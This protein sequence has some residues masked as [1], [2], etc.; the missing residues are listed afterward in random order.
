M[1]KQQKTN[2]Y[3]PQVELLSDGIPVYNGS[4]AV[5]EKMTS[6]ANSKQRTDEFDR[7]LITTKEADDKWKEAFTLPNEF[8]Q[9]WNKKRK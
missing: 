7:S 1:K 5:N 4:E 2:G 8:G 6:T 9:H 3:G